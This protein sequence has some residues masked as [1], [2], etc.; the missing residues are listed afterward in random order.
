[1]RIRKK[2]E[3]PVWKK[4][5]RGFRGFPVMTVAYYGPD[6]LRATKV[7]VGLVRSE[8]DEAEILD[9]IFTTDSDARDDPSVRKRVLAH[10]LEHAPKSIAMS[11]AIAGCPHEEGVD[12]AEGTSCPHC[13]AWDRVNPLAAS[14][15]GLLG[16]SWLRDLFG[17]DGSEDDDPMDSDDD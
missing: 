9:R 5:K 6:D 2:S 12:Y 11:R 16:K 13:P 4:A 8:D 1:M 15:A 17:S 14:R 7:A 3:D 10:Y